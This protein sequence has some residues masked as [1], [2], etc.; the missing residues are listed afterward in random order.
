MGEVMVRSCLYVPASR[1]AIAQGLPLRHLLAITSPTSGVQHLSTGDTFS[2]SECEQ[3]H[4]EQ[5]DRGR[6]ERKKEVQR[7]GGGSGVCV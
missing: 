7:R 1:I 3:V 2:S 4:Y 6:R 5:T